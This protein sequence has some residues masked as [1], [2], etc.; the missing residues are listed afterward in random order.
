[1]RTIASPIDRLRELGGE[2]RL[3]GDKIRYRIPATQEAREV[4]TAIRRDRDAVIAMLR[5]SGSKPPTLEEVEAALPV[6][7]RLVSY[8]PK[9]APFAVVPVSVV[10]NAGIF[11]RTH[12][13]DLRARLEKPDGYQCPSLADIMSKLADAGLELKIGKPGAFINVHGLEISNDDL[14]F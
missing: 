2:L 11:Y 13:R 5:D 8:Q 7:V 4:I 10:T 14:P 6:G 12:L 3:E 1:M 9:E